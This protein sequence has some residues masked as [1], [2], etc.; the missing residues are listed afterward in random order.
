M[1]TG[2]FDTYL[3]GFLI[4]ISS[5]TTQIGS[6]RF[7]ELIGFVVHCLVLQSDEVITTIQLIPVSLYVKRN[8]IYFDRSLYTHWSN[9]HIPTYYIVVYYTIV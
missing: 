4:A 5:H 1:S 6:H 9:V 8:H 7:K 3:N 2:L